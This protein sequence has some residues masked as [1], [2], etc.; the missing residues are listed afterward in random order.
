MKEKILQILQGVN[1]EIREGVNLIQEGIIDSFAVVNIVLELEETFEI[2]IDPELIISENFE[3]I[4]TI[5]TL[6][7]RTILQ[8]GG[9]IVR[10]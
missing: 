10:K 4:E 6:V 8:G 3:T 1:E 2:E 5:E 7:Q 9:G